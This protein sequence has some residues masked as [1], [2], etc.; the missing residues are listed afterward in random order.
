MVRPSAEFFATFCRTESRYRKTTRRIYD[1]LIK[2][3]IYRLKFKIHPHLF[4]TEPL[5]LN[6]LYFVNSYKPKELCQK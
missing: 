2:G 5:N 4:A 1:K 6:A 3:K